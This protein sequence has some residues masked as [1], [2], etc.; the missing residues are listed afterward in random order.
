MCVCVYMYV[1]KCM[2]VCLYVCMC[3]C[4]CMYIC[5]YVCIYIYVCNAHV[6]LNSTHII[7]MYMFLYML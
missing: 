3:L 2:F 5:M 6:Y 7:Y 4:V 1:C